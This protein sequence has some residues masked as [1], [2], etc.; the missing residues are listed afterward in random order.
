MVF[1][2]IFGKSSQS[3]IDIILNNNNLSD[4]D[5][6]GCINNKCK[7][8]NEDILSSIDGVQLTSKQKLRINIV[9]DHI[10]YFIN[11]IGKLDNVIDILVKPYETYIDLL[12]T[13]PGIKRNSAIGILS[14]ISN[15]SL[16]LNL[17]TALLHGQV[18]LLA[19]MNLLARKNLLKFLAPV[20]ILNH[21]LLKLL[22]VRLKIKLIPTMQRNLKKYLSDVARNAPIL[23]LLE[24]F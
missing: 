13:I 5:I 7:S 20:F 1:S 6:I 23:Q 12:C 18:V 10:D 15:D 2:D 3:I 4:E 17:I 22:I 21:I 14:E 19:V 9:K 24:K 16:N 11:Q 8:S